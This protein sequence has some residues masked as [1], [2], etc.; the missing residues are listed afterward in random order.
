MGAELENAVKATDMKAQ[1]D[2]SAKRL[3]GNKSIL[4]H[5][6]VKAVDEFKGMKPKEVVSFIEGDPYISSIPV[7][8]GL[9]NKT[10]NNCEKLVGFNTEDC[11]INEGLVKFDIVFYVR[12]KDG[13]SQIIVNIEA[14]KDKPK[15]YAIVNRGIY[16]VSR[17]I[18]SQKERDFNGS[19]Y[20]DI[21]R[22]YSIWI[23]MNMDENILSH[24][25]L[26]KEDL[27][28]KY[29]WKGN[30]DIFNIIMIG[31]SKGLPENS[32][33][34]EL[35][36]LLGALLS[37]ELTAD[38]RLGIIGKEY[39]ITVEEKLRKD[40]GDMCNLSQGI[41]EKG[42]EKGIEKGK[43]QIIHNMHNKGFTAEQ[44][45]MAVNKNIEE[46]N[47]IIDGKELVLA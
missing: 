6:L 23:C 28:G 42:I 35:H 47:A 4:A 8:S 29:D 43:T 33:M 3:L 44:I 46:I 26:T 11:E 31:L 27:V 22:V 45:A 14:Q 20:D 15:S 17:L 5:I 7:E 41:E 12:M 9:T 24:I 32:E 34:Y 40:V 25:Y 36:R 18:S 10:A 1:Y 19:H 37:Q 13:L 2:A 38:D 30:L 16:Y 39:D 21:K